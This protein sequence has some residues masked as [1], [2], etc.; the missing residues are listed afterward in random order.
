MKRIT[1]ITD[2]T[3]QRH[4]IV[5]E[6]SEIILTLRY[7]P[8]TQHWTFDAEFAGRAVYGVKLS[9]GVLHMTSQ[10]QPFD[11]FVTDRS[12][13]G[14]DPFQIN[15]FTSGRCRLYML[16]TEEMVAVRAGAEVPLP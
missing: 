12:G 5:F 8:K 3:I 1:N 11:F 10:N 13:N 2:E 6:E 7:Y 4:I 14:I 15:D 16:E 9:V